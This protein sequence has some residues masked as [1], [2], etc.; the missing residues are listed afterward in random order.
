[1]RGMEGSISEEEEGPI[2][3]DIVQR[4][5]ARLP[6][7]PCKHLFYSELTLLGILIHPLELLLNIFIDKPFT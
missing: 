6:I 5:A 4:C 7:E 3:V 1:M 2:I